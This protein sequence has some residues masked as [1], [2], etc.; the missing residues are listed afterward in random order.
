MVARHDWVALKGNKPRESGRHRKTVSRPAGQHSEAGMKSQEGLTSRLHGLR[1]LS[2]DREV[3]EPRGGIAKPIR[4][5]DNGVSSRDNPTAREED[6]S[7]RHG[8]VSSV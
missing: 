3:D 6:G 2:E 8:A 1:P 4:R 7:W 5:Q